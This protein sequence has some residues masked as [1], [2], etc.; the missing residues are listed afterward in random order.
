MCL[1]HRIWTATPNQSWITVTDGSAGL[2]DGTVEFS[3][4]ANPTP[5]SRGGYIHISDETT[6]G[7]GVAFSVIQD[8][9]PCTYGLSSSS[10]LFSGAAGADFVGVTSLLGC[11]FS[12]RL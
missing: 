9:A 1:C 7:L 3:V 11:T 10:A 2:S 12:Q 5:F 4:D 8:P 6:G